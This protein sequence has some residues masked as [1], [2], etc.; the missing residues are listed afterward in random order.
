MSKKWF[1]RTLLSYIPVFFVVTAFL[2]FIFFQTLSEQNKKETIKANSFVAEQAIRFIDHSLKAIDEKVTL[3]LLRNQ[4][5]AAF[6]SKNGGSDLKLEVSV[7]N[8]MRDLKITNPL[9]DSIYIVRFQDET[10]LS[11][12][13]SYPLSRYPDQ[14]FITSNRKAPNSVWSDSRSFKEFSYEPD[15]QVVSLTRGFPVFTQEKG[16]VVVNVKTESLYGLIRQMYNP[17]ISFIRLYGHEGSE[18]SDASENTGKMVQEGGKVYASYV[19]DYTGWRV[20]SGIKKTGLTGL[21]LDLYNIWIGLGILVVVGAVGWIVYVTRRNYKPIELIVSR[22]EIFLAYKARFIGAGADANVFKFI[23]SAL[24][25]MIEQSNQLERQYYQDL[26]VR[27]NYFINEL[28][29]GT[30][31]VGAEEWKQ[32]AEQL[33]MPATFGRQIVFV[34]EIDK[35]AE[36]CKEYNHRDQNLMKFVISKAVEETAS[37]G[38]ESIWVLW[39]SSHQLTCVLRLEEEAGAEQS[40]DMALFE[41]IRS[42]LENNLQLTVTIGIGNRAEQPEGLRD[43]YNEALEALRYKAVYGDN[44]LIDYGKLPSRGEANEHMR[45]ILSIVDAYRLAQDDWLDKLKTL[46]Q[47]MRRSV[48]SRD[49][50]VSLLHSLTFHLNRAVSSIGPQFQPLWKDRVFPQLQALP[51][52]FEMLEEIEA[53]YTL[54]L[55]QFADELHEL[56]DAKTNHLAIHEVK[57]YLEHNFTNP[58]LSLDFLSDQFG[59]NGKYVSKLFKEAYGVKFVDYLIDLRIEHAKRMLKETDNT[60]Q[61]IAESVGYSSAISFIRTFKKVTGVSPGDY[62]KEK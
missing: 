21:I 18:L 29:K 56:R 41:S 16:M 37:A 36:F 11:S 15:S 62:R 1:Y 9:I 22:L 46:F 45:L 23:E 2:F 4:D 40:E 35:Y 52:A 14:P 7:M 33:L 50:I 10:V 43:S 5:L 44:C 47:A 31:R 13:T 17:D 42:W 54:V 20:D 3:E 25:S 60:V 8:A 24:D 30:R 59:M 53:Q 58:N 55:R 39:T 27:R 28:L 51:D 38:E 12:S 61:E 49:D 26:T 19:S 57:A 32:E 6:L 48:L 34:V